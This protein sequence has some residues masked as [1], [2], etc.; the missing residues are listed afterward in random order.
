MKGKKTG[1][2]KVGSVNKVTAISKDMIAEMISEY[3]S[4]GMMISDFYSLEPKDRLQI[5]EKLMNYVVPKIQSVAIDISQSEQ[6]RTIEDDLAEL[7]KD[8]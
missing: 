8:P 7:A 6:N 2:R 1:G 4:S 3:K 5:S